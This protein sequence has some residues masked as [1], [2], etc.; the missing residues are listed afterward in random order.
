MSGI[1]ETRR[2]NRH[3]ARDFINMS[4]KSARHGGDF[5]GTAEITATLSQKR[6]SNIGGEA[7]RNDDTHSITFLLANVGTI[8]LRLRNKKAIFFDSE[9]LRIEGWHQRKERHI[10]RIKENDNE[11]RAFFSTNVYR[12]ARHEKGKT[13]G[14]RVLLSGVTNFSINACEN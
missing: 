7:P 3:D 14:P 8:N 10:I 1:E 4:I 6:A 5:E 9:L 11:H 12:R 2:N 13:N